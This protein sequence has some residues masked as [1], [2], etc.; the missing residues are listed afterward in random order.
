MGKPLIPVIDI[1][2]LPETEA[3]IIELEEN[4]KR[5]DLTWQERCRAAADIHQRLEAKDPEWNQSRTAERLGVT[6]QS[7]SRYIA[8]AEAMRSDFEI[9]EAAS[10]TTAFNI[11]QRK[12]DR[13]FDDMLVGI[14]EASKAPPASTS[15]TS[16][17]LATLLPSVIPLTTPEPT[18]ELR[19][20]TRDL[21]CED[22][23]EWAATYRGPKFNFVHC[24]FPYGA[25]AGLRNS[26]INVGKDLPTY[27]DSPEIFWNLCSV[28]LDSFDN[29]VS[30]SAHMMVWF[31][32]E[33]L[34]D[35]L[36]FFKSFEDALG[37]RT[38]RIPL[39][40][41]KSDNSG[42][43]SD[44]AR[45]A[46]HIYETALVISR[47]DRKIIRSVSDVYSCPI[48]RS[49]HPAEK[50]EPMLR[51][52]FS[53]FVDQ[54][55]RMLDPTAGSGTSLRAAESLGAASVFGIEKSERYYADAV[56]ELNRFRSKARMNQLL[57]KENIHDQARTTEQ[58]SIQG[59]GK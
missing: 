40:W 9:E 47:G 7:V 57:I 1:E 11:L 14:A 50:P 5:V 27:E 2:S 21:I 31:Q 45:R 10:L 38:F 6:S 30:T 33:L 26:Q 53:M 51:Y 22:F 41:H 54:Q 59:A 42:V 55:S 52:F 20:A 29:V 28:L 17:N 19:P 58:G 56:I 16:L 12:Q 25:G 43:V 23:T 15:I 46:R 18:I 39:I 44:A 48:S 3:K 32:T 34:S 13:K 49:I 35:V 4:L 24:D 36:S 37:F 8:L